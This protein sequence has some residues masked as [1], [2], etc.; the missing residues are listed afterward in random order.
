MGARQ[1]PDRMLFA[2][3]RQPAAGRRPPLY[4]EHAATGRPLPRVTATDDSVPPSTTAVRRPTPAATWLSRRRTPGRRP[5]ST[6]DGSRLDPPAAR[7]LRP[8]ADPPGRRR[9]VRRCRTGVPNRP[10]EP[11]VLPVPGEGPLWSPGS[12]RSDLAG[13]EGSLRPWRPGRPGRGPAARGD[14]SDAGRRRRAPWTS[15]RRTQLLVRHPRRTA[16]ALRKPTG[17]AR[18]A[19]DLVDA[20]GGK[21]ER[22]PSDAGEER[23]HELVAPLDVPA[24]SGGHLGDEVEPEAALAGVAADG[25]GRRSGGRLVGDLDQVGVVGQ[26]DGRPHLAAAVPESVGRHLVQGEHEL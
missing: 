6:H 25:R 9:P 2:R 3:P 1:A 21:P 10:G 14:G 7:P 26:P 19:I 16:G 13:G 5:T 17:S 8:G 22:A 20:R 23:P 15:C 4:P 12:D 24:V 11:Q 18:P